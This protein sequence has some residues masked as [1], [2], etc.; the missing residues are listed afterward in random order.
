MKIID[1]TGKKFDKL[2]VIRHYGTD[3]TGKNSTWLCKC[4]CGNETIVSA[5]HLKT[6]HTK[7]C[8]CVRKEGLRGSAGWFKPKHGKC[9]TRLYSIWSNMKDRCN[10]P[11]NHKAKIYHDRG[12]RLCKEWAENFQAFY[13]WAMA[14]GYADN[15]TID[16]ID[17]D[18]GYSPDNCR[19]A[20]YQMQNLNRRMPWKKR[21]D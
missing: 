21:G 10:N 17:N 16:R 5:T 4:E 7:S 19:W 9:Q 8:G 12:I 18:K 14:N 2:T 15:L 20:T 1:L 3:S 13:D 11:N 6:G